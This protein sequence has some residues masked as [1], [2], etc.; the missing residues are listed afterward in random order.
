MQRIWYLLAGVFALFGVL[1]MARVIERLITGEE[2]VPFQ[3]LIAVLAL[4]AAFISFNRARAAAVK[5]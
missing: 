2:W 5:K 1:N 4:F 3:S